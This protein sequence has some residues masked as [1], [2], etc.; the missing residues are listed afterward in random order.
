MPS[1]EVGVDVRRKRALDC[2]PCVRSL[3]HSPEAVIHSSAGNGCG[4]ANHGH[5]ILMPPYL[6]AQNAEAVLGIVVGDALRPHVGVISVDLMARKPEHHRSFLDARRAALPVAS[7]K[8]WRGRLSV[9]NL[10]C[11]LHGSSGKQVFAGASG[12]ATHGPNRAS[13]ALKMESL[14]QPG[15]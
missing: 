15:V 9:A 3:T 12:G 10:R 1:A 2:W 8:R 11:S 7:L 13:G 4:M 5:D 14:Q 6:G